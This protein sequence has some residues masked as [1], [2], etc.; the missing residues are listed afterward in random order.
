[1]KLPS[2]IQLLRQMIATPSL[3]R[4]EEATADLI[5]D[6][7]NDNG[8]APKRI[9][10]NVYALNR[11]YDPAKPTVMLNSHHDTV[12]AA[13]SYTRDPHDA[14]IINGKLYGLGSNDAGA[15][16]VSLTQVFLDLY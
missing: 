2:H 12:K 14:V 15:S 7:L 4:N 10:N 16:V 1:M 6:F 5:F 13:A 3:S 8:V 9:H 11:R